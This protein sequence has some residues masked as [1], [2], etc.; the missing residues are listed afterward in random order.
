[1]ASRL[2]RAA[3][4]ACAPQKALEVLMDV[5]WVEGDIAGGKG[6]FGIFESGFTLG[7]FRQRDGSVWFTAALPDGTLTFDPTRLPIVWVDTSMVCDAGQIAEVGRH[8][9]REAA[10]K[11]DASFMPLHMV[12]DTV[13]GFRVWHGVE[14]KG[15]GCV[16]AL[17]SGRRMSLRYFVMPHDT[18]DVTISLEGLPPLLRRT[19]GVG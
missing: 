13:I 4:A 18:I 5:E 11:D 3:V 10:A 16:G 6:T 8:A 9:E 12:G 17:L 15:L 7:I 14:A 2:R 1:M 19:L